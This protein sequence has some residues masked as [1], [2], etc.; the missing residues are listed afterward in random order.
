[1][2]TSSESSPSTGT[3][4]PSDSLWPSDDAPVGSEGE[5]FLGPQPAAAGDLVQERVVER[6]GDTNNPDRLAPVDDVGSAAR[7]EGWHRARQQ[8][9]IRRERGPWGRLGRLGER[10]P[11]SP[12]QRHL[13][14]RRAGQSSCLFGGDVELAGDAAVCSADRL[15]EA[16]IGTL[17]LVAPCRSA[18]CPGDAR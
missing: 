6:H 9:A 5:A 7:R 14:L 2:P 13:D 11:I 16:F 15:A 12:A 18:E 1:M 8:L 4:W 3:G 10:G 17:K